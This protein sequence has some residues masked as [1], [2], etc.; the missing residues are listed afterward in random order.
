MSDYET[1]SLFPKR[2]PDEVL[3]DALREHGEPIASFCLFSGGND[4]TVVAHRCRDWY[5]ELV[6]IDTGTAVPGVRA[7]VETF[8]GWIG[9]PLRVYEAPRDEYRRMVLGSDTPRPN[10]G[11]DVG[12]GF[13][14]P[15]QHGTCYARL[16]ERQV[17]RLI[18]DAQ[19]ECR[20]G[21]GARVLLITGLRRSESERRRARAESHRKGAQV[22]VNPLI[23]WTHRDMH[24]YRERHGLPTSDVAAL[25]HRSGECNCGA[26]AAPG[27]RAE[28]AALYPEW[29]EETIGSLERAA[30]AV[31]LPCRWGE[32]P[33]DPVENAGEMCSDCQLRLSVEAAA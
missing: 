18:R 16:K 9:K 21:R 1:L 19:A 8:A 29:F 31:G 28:L 14:G 25:L 2:D 12:A 11:P 26:F 4:S 33:G 27:E 13:P 30:A 7:F 6:H 24:L 20:R 23:D 32:R 17:R 22:W 3:A 15:A 5:D 10:G